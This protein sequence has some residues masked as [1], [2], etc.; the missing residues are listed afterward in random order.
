MP[1]SQPLHERHVLGALDSGEPILDIWLR[2]HAYGSEARRTSRT[3]VWSDGDVVTAF[4]TISAHRLVRA[5]LPHT[6][7]RGSP[8]EIPAVLLGK[9]ALDRSLHGKG[10]GG[11]LLAD[12]LSRIVRATTTV[13][14]R[15][16]VVD[17]LHPKAA[18]FYEHFGFRRIPV[19]GGTC[20]LV[21]KVSNVATAL[22]DP[23]P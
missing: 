4:Y 1:L 6:V 18:A 21:Q 14:A 16:V 8:R 23:P 19:P 22:G 7:G 13:G 12:A 15:F 11:V 10:L 17:A 3:F 9:L 2:E 5:E 20:R